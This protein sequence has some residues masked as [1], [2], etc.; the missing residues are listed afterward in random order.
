MTIDGL[1]VQGAADK[2]WPEIREW[3]ALDSKADPDEFIAQADGSRWIWW[4]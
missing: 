1:L 2:E 3:L 4:D